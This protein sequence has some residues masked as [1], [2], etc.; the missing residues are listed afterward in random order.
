MSAAVRSRFCR[1]A[2]ELGSFTGCH[3]MPERSF[4][5][6]GRQFPVCARCTGVFA[7]QLAALFLFR[8][9]SP[10][11]WLLAAFC[12]IMLADWLVQRFGLREST[13]LRRLITGLLCGYALCT[14]ALRFIKFLIHHG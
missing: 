10:P 7:G 11:Y 14:L 8:L 1:R 13:N 4:F 2:M 12:A 5:W 9:V 6:H 3:Q